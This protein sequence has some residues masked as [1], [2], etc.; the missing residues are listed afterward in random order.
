MTFHGSS[1]RGTGGLGL[2]DAAWLRRLLKANGV[3]IAKEETE[4]VDVEAIAKR[5]GTLTRAQVA[6]FL[7]VST[8]TVQRL[9]ADGRLGRCR[10]LGGAVRYPARDVLKLASAQ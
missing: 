2:G 8:K 10:S 9:E 1:G 4:P 5:G 3:T 7:Q 6:E